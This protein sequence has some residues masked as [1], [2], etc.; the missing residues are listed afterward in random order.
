[1]QQMEHDDMTT[2]DQSEQQAPDRR[3]TPKDRRSGSKRLPQGAPAAPL[4]NDG[5]ELVRDS[6]C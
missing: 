3:E 6:H 4:V 2:K 1:M 5:L